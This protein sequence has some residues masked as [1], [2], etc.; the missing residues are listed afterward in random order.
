MG[1]KGYVSSIQAKALLNTSK[2]IFWAKSIMIIENAFFFLIKCVKMLLFFLIKCTTKRYIASY[3]SLEILI[4]DEYS[5]PGRAYFMWKLNSKH[6]Y[7]YLESLFK[8]KK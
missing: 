5:S 6:S 8:T 7:K 1:N 2:F 4:V 3:A